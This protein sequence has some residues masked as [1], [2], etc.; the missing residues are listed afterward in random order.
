ML[1]VLRHR[2]TLGLAL[3]VWVGSGGVGWR[4]VVVWW[5]WGWWWRLWWY[6][7]V[8]LVVVLVLVMVVVAVVVV[9]GVGVAADGAS[10]LL[11][12]CSIMSC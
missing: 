5:C 2:P 12:P 6:S 8:L 9:A 4:V 7:W 3:C 10:P 11:R 1:M